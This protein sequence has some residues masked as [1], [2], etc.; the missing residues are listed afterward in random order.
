MLCNVAFKYNGVLLFKIVLLS[1]I[2]RNKEYTEIIPE[3]LSLGKGGRENESYYCYHYCDSAQHIFNSHHS[4]LLR[5]Y[6]VS[7][8]QA[9]P[10]C[11]EGCEAKYLPFTGCLCPAFHLS[12]PAGCVS[13]DFADYC[14]DWL[15][16]RALIKI[17]TNI[18]VYQEQGFSATTL[19]H[20]EGDSK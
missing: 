16:Q 3:R 7:T 19:L 14:A 6:C 12:V 5:A 17:S 2:C 4:H 8:L 10:C 11:E 1:G 9:A 18:L 15:R 20:G 13:M